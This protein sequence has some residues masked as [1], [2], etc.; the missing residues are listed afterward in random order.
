MRNKFLK[1][2]FGVL[3][4]FVLIRNDAIAS[5]F[6][7]VTVTREEQDLYRV[8]GQNLYIKTRYC[9]E[10]V[11]YEDAILRIDS[12]SGFNIGIIIFDNGDGDKCD[13]EKLLR[14]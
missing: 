5:E 4:I 2:L 1:I 14:G 12:Q 7:Q 10:Y 8:L 11:Y 6:Y 3:L 13:V 9:Y